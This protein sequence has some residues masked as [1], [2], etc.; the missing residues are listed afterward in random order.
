MPMSSDLFPNKTM[1]DNRPN[2]VRYAAANGISVLTEIS[3]IFIFQ[4]KTAIGPYLLNKL[5]QRNRL[6]VYILER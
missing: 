1:V 4:I 3:V 5:D 6:L 2:T